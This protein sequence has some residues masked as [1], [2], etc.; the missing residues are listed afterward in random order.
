MLCFQITFTQLLNL[1]LCQDEDKEP[2]YWKI[3][4]FS[5]LVLPPYVDYKGHLRIVLS[6][7]YYLIFMIMKIIHAHCRKLGN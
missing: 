1:A 4:S 5:D 7:L 3:K 2:L 6:P